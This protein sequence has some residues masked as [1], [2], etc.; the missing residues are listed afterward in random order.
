MNFYGCSL[1]NN[2]DSIQQNSNNYKEKNKLK[3]R[4][5]TTFR[6][7]TVDCRTFLSKTKIS[8]S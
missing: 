5:N 7:Q 2:N 8:A 4:A 3:K 1:K 6:I